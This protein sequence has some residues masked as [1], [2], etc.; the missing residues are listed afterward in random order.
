M[1]DQNLHVLVSRQLM[2]GILYPI[3]VIVLLIGNYTFQLLGF[4]KKNQKNEVIIF[5]LRH[6]NIYLIKM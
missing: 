4:S 6:F 5:F 3:T 1:L 2:S